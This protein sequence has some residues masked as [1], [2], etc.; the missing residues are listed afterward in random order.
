MFGFFKAKRAAKDAIDYCGTMLAGID[1][2]N[3]RPVPL[4]ALVDPYVL[5]FQQQVIVF[6]IS[7]SNGH[8]PV[9]SSVMFSA[10]RATYNA[11]VPGAAK[12]I[13]SGISDLNRPEHQFHENYMIGQRGGREYVEALDE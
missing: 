13:M 11:L 3:E 6:A 2:A 8:R 12:D 1:T 7:A 9:D 10:C 4:Q 5:G